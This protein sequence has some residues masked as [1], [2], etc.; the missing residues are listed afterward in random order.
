[1]GDERPCGGCTACCSV[2]GVK[3]LGKKPWT[4]CKHLEETGCK[5]Y[6][7]RPAMC[8]GFFCLWQGGAGEEDERP[9][10]LGAI[11]A[12]SNGPTEFTGELE[13]QSKYVD[14]AGRL[15]QKGQTV[16]S[17]PGGQFQEYGLIVDHHEI[18]HAYSTIDPEG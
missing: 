17:A 3:E 10:R 13:Y 8:K 12:L 16:A 6:D 15:K 14:A 11:F 5:I 1:M 9:D 2:F 7:K 4:G 18:S